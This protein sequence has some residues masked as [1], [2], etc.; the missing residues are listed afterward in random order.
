MPRD[1]FL[2]RAQALLLDL[3]I[4]TVAMLTAGF[5]VGTRSG[6][7]FAATDYNLAY[8]HFNVVNQHLSFHAMTRALNVP[9]GSY[10]VQVRWRR[11]T[12]RTWSPLGSASG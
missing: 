2:L 11:T 7:S 4:V 1:Q 5:V 8:E 12:V 9:A 3:L 6:S 10:T